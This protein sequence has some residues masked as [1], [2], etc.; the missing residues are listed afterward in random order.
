MT[1]PFDAPAVST[2]P[3][4]D[5]PAG[6]VDVHVVIVAIVL[7]VIALPP[8][9][10]ALIAPFVLAIGGGNDPEFEAMGLAGRIAV[11]CIESVFLGGIGG[12]YSVGGIGL[13]TR[14]RWG[15]VAALLGAQDLEDPHQHGV[16]RRGLGDPGGDAV[17]EQLQQHVVVARGVGDHERARLDAIDLLEEDQPA[18]VFDLIL[19]LAC[20]GTEHPVGVIAQRDEKVHHHGVP[21]P[22]VE[23]A[24]RRLDRLDAQDLDREG[25]AED[26]GED[27]DVLGVIVDEQESAQRRHSI[28]SKSQILRIS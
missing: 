3:T 23:G 4:D 19:V 11:G 28:R 20:A 27:L 9:L 1:D 18:E 15:W 6:E 7:L 22:I 21:R 16:D 10:L 24:H 5:D 17:L 13:L 26:R 14:W 12:A 25:L 2:V 8:V